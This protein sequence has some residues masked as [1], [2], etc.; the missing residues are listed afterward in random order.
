M[1]FQGYSILERNWRVDHLEVD[2]IAQKRGLLVFVEVKTLA[3][4]RFINPEEHV[5]SGKRRNIVR[6]AKAYLAMNGLDQQVRFDIIA[7]TGEKPPFAVNHIE[8]AFETPAA[9]APM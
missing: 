4:D 1:M 7:V 9:F 8:N 3:S 5:D 6:A 2:I